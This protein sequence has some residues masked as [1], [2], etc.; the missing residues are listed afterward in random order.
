MLNPL[1]SVVMSA[2]NE[3]DC[4]GAAIRSVLDQSFRDFEF[5]ILDD[6]ST[7]DT[8]ARIQAFDD[9]RIRLL[10]N[11][12]NLKLAASLNRGLREARGIYIARMDADDV[13]LPGRLAK[14]V[15]FMEANP[16][17][18]VLGGAYHRILRGR[19]DGKIRPSPLMHG[20]EH[21][22]IAADVFFLHGGVLH[23][24]ILFRRSSLPKSGNLYDESFP[25]GEDDELWPRL[26][27]VARFAN[28][29]EPL[30]RYRV[31]SEQQLT[32]KRGDFDARRAVHC[33]IMRRNLGYL[34]GASDEGAIALAPHLCPGN[35]ARGLPWQAAADV[36]SLHLRLLREN[37]RQRLYHGPS[38]ARCSAL[39]F[40]RFLRRR[41]GLRTWA[42]WREY[43]LAREKD[44][45][46]SPTDILRPTRW[47]RA[48]FL[49][50]SMLRKG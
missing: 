19:M 50:R 9:P 14:Q 40:F 32:S 48:C 4:I 1:V 22:R 27:R 7:D 34:L 30:I 38:F 26:A 29:A 2:W 49:L 44:H 46:I 28:L 39:N 13:A 10:R 15:E 37:A 43:L 17:I 31:S 12:S 41:P 25:T 47:R 5:I 21:E 18:G 20:L 11:E 45:G 42:L 33:R 23:P 6:A 35:S 16:A 8:V 36:C 3:A 24:T